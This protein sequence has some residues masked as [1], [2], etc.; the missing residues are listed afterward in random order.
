MAVR[1]TTFARRARRQP[2]S[3]RPGSADRP[4]AEE[5]REHLSFASFA[6]D[7]AAAYMFAFTDD[8]VASSAATDIIAKPASP[9]DGLAAWA[10]AVSPFR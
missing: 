10:S 7:V 5:R 8:D 6:V 9:S 1:S 3:A 4:A 2:R